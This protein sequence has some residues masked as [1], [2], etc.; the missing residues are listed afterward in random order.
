MLQPPIN[1]LAANQPSLNEALSVGN[2]FQQ[3]QANKM[4]MQNQQEA[5][6]RKDSY[7][8]D[9]G[10][11]L[12]SNDLMSK[13]PEFRN[14]TMQ[15]A[16]QQQAMQSQGLGEKAFMLKQDPNNQ[17]L[18]AEVA[19][20]YADIDPDDQFTN[21]SVTQLLQ[22]ENG[23]QVLDFLIKS[24]G[25]DSGTV[26]P[27]QT[28]QQS[29]FEYV[30][31]LSEEDRKL[32]EKT[33]RGESPTPNQQVDLKNKLADIEV[34]TTTRKEQSKANVKAKSGY[35]ERARAAGR[36]ISTIN[37]LKSINN[38]AFSGT[39]AGVGLAIAKAAKTVG[40][41]TEGLSESEQFQALAN[42]LVLDKSQQ[43][44]GALSNADMEFLRNTAPTLT[45]TKDGR[46]AMLDYSEKLAKR[47]QETNRLAN[48]YRKKN[49][50]FDDA[51]F[52]VE[53]QKYADENPLFE[54]DQATQEESENKSVI[55]SLI[56][57]DVTEGDIQETMR[58]NNLTREQ[59]LERL[60]GG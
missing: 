2:K 37:K 30:K 12:N 58:A 15:F 7:F 43:M 45:N 10:A 21:E 24:G 40:I 33:Q 38:K 28:A 13:Y 18:L 26:K 59:V 3:M 36:E 52:Q 53:M 57:G 25:F 41:E 44:S 39:G 48:E 19:Q 49:G 51:E 35:A 42:T 4:N 5:Q 1:Y 29:N 9:V 47:E 8:N 46:V 14:E 27:K 6:A 31:N 16:Q 54:S 11:G 60:Q 56:Y 55:S 23:G 34:K 20:G 17:G 50:A 22:G 32:Y